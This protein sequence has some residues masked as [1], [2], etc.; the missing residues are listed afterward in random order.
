MLEKTRGIV[1]NH[2]KFGEKSLVTSIYT[3]LLGRKSF[4][5]QRIYTKKSMV[6]PTFFQPLTL[7]DIQVDLKPNRD[8]QRIREIVLIQPFL[9]IPF[10]VS[11]RAIT[12]FLAEILTKT[13]KEE[14]ANPGL[15]Q[16]LFTSIQL[17]DVTDT[18]IANFHLVFLMNFARYLGCYPTDNYSSAN[19]LFDIMNGNFQSQPKKQAPISKD[20]SYLLHKLLTLTYNDMDALLLD[21]Q[22]RTILLEVIIAYYNLHMGGIGEIKSLPVL[23]HI[24]ED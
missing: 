18:S 6:H 20:I 16:Y 9:T 22:K 7:L 3:E 24:F 21:H 19:C 10:D 12:L 4:L 15:F 1:L 8:L 23:Q 17:L 11:K 13:I 2:V 5:I 14:E